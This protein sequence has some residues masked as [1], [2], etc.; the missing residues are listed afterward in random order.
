[1]G[2]KKKGKVKVAKERV[3]ERAKVVA[4]HKIPLL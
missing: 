4:V 1:M 2:G 3:R